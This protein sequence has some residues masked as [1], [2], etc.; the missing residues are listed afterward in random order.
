MLGPAIIL[1][2][3]FVT[4]PA[5]GQWY[6]L[7]AGFG[8]SFCPVWDQHCQKD[9]GTSC[10]SFLLMSISQF[11]LGKC[12][13]MNKAIKCWKHYILYIM[14]FPKEQ[15]IYTLTLLNQD[16][17]RPKDNALKSTVS[18]VWGEPPF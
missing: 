1:Y 3:S 12:I 13:Q 7:G 16:M 9:F 14:C 15:E 18:Q 17:D 10:F 5:E 4:V 8:V 6:E 2:R 11:G